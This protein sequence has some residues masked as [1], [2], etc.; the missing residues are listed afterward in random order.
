MAGIPERFPAVAAAMI[1]REAEYSDLPEWSRM[2]TVLWPDTPDN[3]VA[4]IQA[5]FDGA[6]IDIVET[7][8]LESGDGALG[9]FIEL[10]IRSFAEG[11]RNKG[12]P[13]IEAWYVD[14]QYR[15]ADWGG[16]LVGAAEQWALGRGYTEIA[17]DTQVGNTSGQAA[18]VALGFKEVE[19]VVCYLKDLKPGRG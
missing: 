14:P 11:S 13:F 6:S 4:E 3:H 10:N 18:H 5:Y 16:K 1:I 15:G 17:S 12:V 7:L 19:R 9:G 2:R 8:V